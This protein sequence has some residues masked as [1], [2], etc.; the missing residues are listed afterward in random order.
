MK[1]MSDRASIRAFRILELFD[2]TRRPMR[3]KELVDSLELPTSSMAELLKSM[4]DA[5]YLTFDTGARTY[6]PTSRVTALADWLMTSMSQYNAVM[7]AMQRLSQKCGELIFLGIA[8]DIYVQYSETIASTHPIQM[9][10]ERGARRLLVQSGMG[11][12]LLSGQSDALI[13]KIYLRSAQLREIDRKIVTLP[14]VMERIEQLRNTGIVYSRNTVY[15]GAGVIATL[16]PIA[17]H[18]RSLA[19]GVAG[20]TSRLDEKLEVFSDML[21]L[22]RARFAYC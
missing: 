14:H 20:P 5:G 11:W 21:L 7:D 18:G 19:L 2:E 9:V 4:T 1:D 16:L 8:N 22:E 17:E 13:E 3:L 12:A 6:L 15:K 10:V